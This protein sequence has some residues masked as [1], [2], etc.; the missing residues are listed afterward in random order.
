MLGRRERGDARQPIWQAAAWRPVDPH[1]WRSAVPRA[2]RRSARLE[3]K[4]GEGVGAGQSEGEGDGW[5]GQ[6]GG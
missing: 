6:N 4:A 1:E 2:D 5:E 3:E